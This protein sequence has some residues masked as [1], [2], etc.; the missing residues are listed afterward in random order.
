MPHLNPRRLIT[1]AVAMLVPGAAVMAQ[2]VPPQGEFSPPAGAPSD[3]GKS[4]N[5]VEPRTPIGDDGFGD[6]TAL[7][8]ITEPGSYYLVGD[9]RDFGNLRNAIRIESTATEVTID[10]NGFTIQSPAPNRALI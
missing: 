8:R 1:L 5:Q 7:I 6:G 2:E 10:L 4:I 9:I 3:S